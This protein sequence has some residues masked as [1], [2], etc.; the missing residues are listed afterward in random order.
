M[1]REVELELAKNSEIKIMEEAV[2]AAGGKDRGIE[3]LLKSIADI[4]AEIHPNYHF[5]TRMSS[6]EPD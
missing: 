3:L 6:K 5:F 2:Q 4:R 1:S